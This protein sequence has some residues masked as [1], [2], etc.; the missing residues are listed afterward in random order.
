[1][2]IYQFFSSDKP[3]DDVHNPYIKLMSINDMIENNMEINDL[4][5]RT[6]KNKDEKI[7]L[8]CDSEEHLYEIEIKKENNISMSY[9]SKYTDKQYISSLEW[10]YTD[11]RAEELVQYIKSQLRYVDEIELWSIWMDKKIEE[12]TYLELNIK[13]LNVFIVKEA[14]GSGLY[15]KPICLRITI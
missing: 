9:I 12:I 11:K 15:E 10:R 2:S 4:L 13:D 7:V 14:I 3:L 8:H 6:T 5:L 1:M